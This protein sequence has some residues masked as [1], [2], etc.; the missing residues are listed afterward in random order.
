MAQNEGTLCVFPADELTQEPRDFDRAADYLELTAFFARHSRVAT[1]DIANQARISAE[2][3]H[4][5]LDTEMRSGEEGLLTGTIERL[6]ARREILGSSA[7]PYDLDVGGDILVCRIQE[8]SLGHAA[9][10]LSLVLSN[11]KALS[12]ILGGSSLHPDD[13]EARQLRE[14]FQYFATAALATEIQGSA[15]SFGFPRPDAFG[16]HHQAK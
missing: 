12:P 8:K 1:S 14:F 11:L 15:W 13:N 10:I 4:S 9:Y 6:E 5:D 16:I 2:Q 7:Y 3:G